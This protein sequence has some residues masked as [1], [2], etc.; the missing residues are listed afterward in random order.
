LLHD[1]TLAPNRFKKLHIDELTVGRL[2]IRE[3]VEGTHSPPLGT[4][5]VLN[6]RTPE[7]TTPSCL[8]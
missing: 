2:R 8:T 7:N 6:P 4:R 5:N 1:E 3:R